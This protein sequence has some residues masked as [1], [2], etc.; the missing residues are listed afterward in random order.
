V[1]NGKHALV[2]GGNH[3]IGLAVARA[4]RDQG[5]RVSVVSRSASGGGFF[6]AA[7]DVSDEGSVTTAFDLCVQ[8]NGS[9]NVL[10]NNAGIAESAPFKRTDRAMWD[11]IIGTNLTGTYL[12]TRLVIENMLA[13]KWGRIVNVASVAGLYGAP[14]ISA[15]CASKHGVLGLTRALAAEL[16]GSGVTV[17]A[18]CPGYTETEMMH[19]AIENIVARTGATAEAARR[20]LAAT[21]AGGRILAAE[22]VA[23]AVVSLCAGDRNGAEVVLPQP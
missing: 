2:T 21:N 9:V 18:V 3:G 6:H 19:R 8:T 22:E 14:Y 13:A 17:N 7:A 11:R 15:Y 1:L 23:E 5:L 4:L 20:Q 12:C 16:P 10:V